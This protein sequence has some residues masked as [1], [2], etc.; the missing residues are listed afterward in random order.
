MIVYHCFHKYKISTASRG[1]SGSMDHHV[2]FC[3][4]TLNSCIVMATTGLSKQ[5]HSATLEFQK[6]KNFNF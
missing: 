4:Y 5:W 3:C 6:R 1:H 2:K